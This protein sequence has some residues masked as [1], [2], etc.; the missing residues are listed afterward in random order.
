[1]VSAP[2]AGTTAATSFTVDSDTQIT[3]TTPAHDAGLVGVSVTTPG[4]T[5][6]VPGLFTYTA[7]LPVP[8]VIALVLPATGPPSG[9]TI[10]T[11]TGVG[12]SGATAVTFGGTPAAS[13]NVDSDV[14]ITA[15]TPAH[16]LGPVDVLVT[17]PAG[18]SLL[19]GLFAYL[20]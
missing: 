20:F 8:P 14:Q 18:T 10:V 11:I 2:V 6:T 1:M 7:P 9:G 5:S 17:T 15:T 3:A 19:P 12:F 16:A 13:F 4:G